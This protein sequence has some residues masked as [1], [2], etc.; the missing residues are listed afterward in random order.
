MVDTCTNC[1]LP[2]P[3]L[4][5]CGPDLPIPITDG[6]WE[7]NVTFI[8]MVCQSK[9]W[10]QIEANKCLSNKLFK[11][12]GD[13]TSEQVQRRLFG[14][15]R[16]YSNIEHQFIAPRLGGGARLVNNM[17]M[18]SDYLDSLPQEACTAKQLI[19]ILNFAFH[20][21]VWSNRSFLERIFH[22]REAVKRLMRRC[23]DNVLIFIKMAHPPGYGK[24]SVRS[25]NWT[26]YALNRMIRSVFG[27]IG[28]HFWE[29]WDLVDSHPS[30]N[31]VHVSKYLLDQQVQLLFSYICPKFG[32]KN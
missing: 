17:V 32:A 1:K 23:H 30:P 13:S 16:S 26:Y 21:R 27:G 20:F 29:L 31:V 11:I 3:T 7:N 8:P 10:S 6:Y 4:P 15:L 24:Q 2:S 14:A 18:E 19:V 12:Y 22:A 5:V 9:Q 28:V 25:S